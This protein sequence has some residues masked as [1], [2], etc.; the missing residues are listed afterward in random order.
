MLYNKVSEGFPVILRTTFSEAA[1]TAPE[2]MPVAISFEIPILSPARYSIVVLYPFNNLNETL[3]Y[4]NCI[5]Q[6]QIIQR[7]HHQENPRLFSGTHWLCY[8]LPSYAPSQG[9][10]IILFHHPLH[11]KSHGP[12][13][14]E[15]NHHLL[16][17]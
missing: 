16:R 2:K 15:L 3:R 14:L 13:Q 12:C 10:A 1:R 8:P 9:Q 17:G 4:K 7:E 6:L 5:K 11:Y